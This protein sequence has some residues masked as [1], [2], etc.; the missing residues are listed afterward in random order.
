LKD[1]VE[2]IALIGAAVTEGIKN[3]CELHSLRFK[4]SMK[5]SDK[6][7]WIE[8]VDVEHESMVEKRYG[9]PLRRVDWKR[10]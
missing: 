1:E 7:K 2:E 3:T 6:D 10:E 8:A 9:L 5:Q 4:D